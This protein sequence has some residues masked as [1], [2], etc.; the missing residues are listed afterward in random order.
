MSDCACNL[1]KESIGVVT[2][3]ISQQT[4]IEDKL[5]EEFSNDIKFDKWANEREEKLFVKNLENVQGDERDIILFSIA[6]GPDEEGK[7]SLNFGPLNKEGGWKGLNVAVSRA[8]SEMVVFTTMTAAMIDLKRTKSKG[9]ESLKN[10]LEFAEKGKIQLSYVEMQQRKE[11]GILDCICLELDKAGY[12]Y[13]KAVGHSKF[14]VDL[15][16]INPFNPDEYILGIMLDGD[17]YKQSANTKDREVAQATVLGTLGWKLHRI[18][19]MDWW[20][21]KD[22]ELS[23]LF[24]ILAARKADYDGPIIEESSEDKP[25]EAVDT[26]DMVS[27]ENEKEIVSG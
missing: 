3:N 2:F 22:K 13:Q 8:R 12:K 23:K 6:F 19:T 18:W 27:N 15:A 21:N 20:D 25:N 16:V 14:K 11:Q 24:D 9:V 5:Q 10:F 17:S 1:G 26:E 7:L 4:L